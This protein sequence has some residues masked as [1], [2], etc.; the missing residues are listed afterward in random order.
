MIQPEDRSRAAA[1]RAKRAALFLGS[2]VLYVALGELVARH[3]VPDA[4]YVWPPNFARSFDPNPEW[5]HG[6][7]GPSRLTINRAGMR[8]DPFPSE[9]SYAILALGGSTTICTYL[10]DTETWP[11]RLQQLLNRELGAGATWVGNVG[12]PGHATA[13]HRLQVEKLL[14]QHPEI[15]AIVLLIG[16]NDF[17]L[18]LGASRNA[19]GVR[20]AAP[21]PTAGLKRA[22]SLFPL[23]RES[24]PW[25]ARTGIGR[26]WATRTWRVAEWGGD[27]PVQDRHGARIADWRRYRRE[28]SSL[29]TT[30]PDL[31]AALDRYERNVSRIVDAAKRHRVRILLLTQPVLWREGLSPAERD[32]LWG[33]GPPLDRVRSGEEYYSVEALAEGM[34]QYNRRLIDVC[35]RRH[36]ECLDLAAELP[37]NAT[38]FWDDAH[39][40]EEGARRVAEHAARYLLQREPLSLLARS[41]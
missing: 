7:H 21:D 38:I 32:L 10:D 24:S 27:Q 9:S 11:H 17:L 40:T 33:G 26:F 20:L 4:Y 37:R 22:F 41:R 29:R 15:D 19:Q 16:I 28:A 39:F 1:R 8:G 2:L 5:I 3:Y 6:I 12:R 35:R 31:S 36:V 30:L 13:Q 14:E 34:R 23:P 18:E 25:Y